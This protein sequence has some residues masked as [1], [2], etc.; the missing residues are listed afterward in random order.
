LHETISIMVTSHTIMRDFSSPKICGW[1]LSSSSERFRNLVYIFRD[2]ML[3]LYIALASI[4]LFD[5]HWE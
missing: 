4:S 3:A 2:K 1:E 5:A